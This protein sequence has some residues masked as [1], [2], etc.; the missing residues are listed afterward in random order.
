MYAHVLVRTCVHAPGF[1]S[2]VIGS[3]V[4]SPCDDIENAYQELPG[5]TTCLICPNNTRRREGKL[6]TQSVKGCICKQDFWAPSAVDGIDCI[7]CPNGALCDGNLHLPYARAGYWAPELR[8][9]NPG[10]SPLSRSENDTCFFNID[11]FPCTYFKDPNS[12]AGG[13]RDESTAMCGP[14]YRGAACSLCEENHYKFN[15]QCYHCGETVRGSLINLSLGALMLGIWFLFNFVI[16]EVVE[17][18]DIFIACVQMSVVIGNFNVDWGEVQYIFNAAALLDFDVDIVS[19]GCI[20]PGSDWRVDICIQLFAPLLL[21]CYYFLPY[22][23]SALILLKGHTF[24]EEQ[25]A[26]HQIQLK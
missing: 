12:C 10:L 5:Q 7:E 4:C 6:A 26:R 15:S 13:K 14:G 2:R 18:V 3:E 16:C 25:N 24:G 8:S 9:C 11:F 22:F 21:A 17:S 20:I 23:A 1:Y 19:L